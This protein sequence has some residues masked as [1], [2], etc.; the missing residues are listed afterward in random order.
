M[1][2]IFTLSNVLRIKIPKTVL[3][4]EVHTKFT[5]KSVCYIFLFIIINYSSLYLIQFCVNVL[6]LKLCGLPNYRYVTL[7]PKI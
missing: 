4:K 3:V 6:I 1:S 2:E 5:I 7:F